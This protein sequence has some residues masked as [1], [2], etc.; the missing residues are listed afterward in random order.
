MAKAALK[1]TTATER[2]YVPRDEA[3]KA[4]KSHTVEAQLKRIYTEHGQLTVD[5]M[6]DQARDPKH[7]LHPHFEWDDSVAGE[8]YRRMQATQMLLASKF[9][10]MLK[11]QTAGELPEVIS[12]G[13]VRQFLPESRG[14][15]FLMRNEV[16][17]DATHRAEFVSRKKAALRSWCKS[18]VDID[19]L[20]PVRDGI[21][22]LIG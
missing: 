8:K 11:K 2:S 13:P 1:L 6:L 14:G 4:R 12:A 21:E 18:V 15:S 19:E 5:L 17:D 3:L 22:A 9:V 16:L 10:C 7:P 20:K